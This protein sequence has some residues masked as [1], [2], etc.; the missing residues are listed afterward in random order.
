LHVLQPLLLLQQFAYAASDAY[1]MLWLVLLVL[2][3]CSKQNG[4]QLCL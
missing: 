1:D 2:V 3:L 4:L